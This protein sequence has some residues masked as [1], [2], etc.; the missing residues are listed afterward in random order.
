MQYQDKKELISLL[1]EM[2]RLLPPMEERK[3]HTNHYEQVDKRIVEAILKL[4]Y[5]DYKTI[6]SLAGK[7]ME[8]HLSNRLSLD[9]LLKC[10]K[11]EI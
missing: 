1:E 4:E 5:S 11:V 7:M 3:H 6:Q 2:K 10:G 8:L 9:E